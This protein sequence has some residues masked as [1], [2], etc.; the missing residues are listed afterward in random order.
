MMRL[1]L[2][3]G[4]VL[5]LSGC[6]QDMQ[7]L[8]TYVEEVKARKSSEIEPL[9]EFKPYEQ[10]VY[11]AASRR[12]PFTQPERATSKSN[13]V[14]TGPRPDPT[15]P[16]E[17]LEDFSIDGLSMKGTLKTNEGDFALIA[18][19]DGVVHMVRVGNYLGENDGKVIEIQP[20]VVRVR[21][22]IADGFGGY[23]PRVVEISMSDVK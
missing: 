17:A 8:K 23:K 2:T 6:G 10:F 13:P 7:D 20:S 4:V 1:L 19:S 15:R 16:R 11:D 14:S 22:L 21:E 3:V 9:P 5:V 12:D 18:S